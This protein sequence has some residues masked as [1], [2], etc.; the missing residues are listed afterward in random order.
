M[1]IPIKSGVFLLTDLSFFLRSQLFYTFETLAYWVI[2]DFPTVIKI[3][4]PLLMASVA[5]MM[6]LYAKRGL[7]WSAPKA[8]LVSFLLAIYF[9]SLR[10][11]WD[12]YA[13]SFGLIFLFA[14]LT[15]LKT[16]NSPRRY[17]F[18]SL[19]MLLTVFSHQ[20]VSVILFFI[21][22]F[23]A[24]R[25]LYR[26]SYRDF[27]FTLIS[28]SLAGAFFLF[29]T[30]SMSYGSIVIP[31]N[32]AVE[33]P[34]TFASTLIGLLL[35]GYGLLFPFAVVGLF[36]LKDWFLRFWV[37]WCLSAMLLLVAFPSLPLYYWP[38]WYY[39]LVYPLLFFATEGLDR[40][41]WLWSQ[42]KN[43][44]KRL[45]PKTV[46]ISYVALLLALSGFAGYFGGV[47]SFD[48]C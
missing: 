2:G 34:F 41:Y 21:L 39:L 3:F 38:R 32:A 13:Q 15:V 36:K 7:G 31:S 11:S 27:L 9:V 23:E 10:N 16:F 17:I 5:V 44:I 48:F 45:L 14:T 30:Y 1:V 22:F 19:F 37:V 29:R 6:F 33:P 8:F 28:L 25:F 20:L 24:L 35:Y 47:C 42:Q 26:K 4:G 43:K 12:L 18:A 40:L 46:A